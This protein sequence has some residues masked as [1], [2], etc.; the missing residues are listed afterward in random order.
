MCLYVELIYGALFSL[1]AECLT[2]TSGNGNVRAAQP[3][4]KDLISVVT[5][6]VKYKVGVVHLK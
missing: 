5:Q 3:L 6:C 2:C 1:Q 4:N